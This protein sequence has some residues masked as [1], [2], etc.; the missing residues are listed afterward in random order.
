MAQG[1]HRDLAERP[2]L[3]PFGRRIVGPVEKLVGGRDYA[4][5][6]SSELQQSNRSK[7]SS[8]EAEILKIGEV[9]SELRLHAEKP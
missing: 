1:Q 3:R 7:L 6:V 9:V 5:K 8:F 2:P 4:T